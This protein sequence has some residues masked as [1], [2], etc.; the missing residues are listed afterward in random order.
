M[1]ARNSKTAVPTV[2]GEGFDLTEFMTGAKGKT[3]SKAFLGSINGTLLA[4][5]LSRFIPGRKAT[6]ADAEG[7][8]AML[9]RD[10]EAQVAGALK[11]LQTAKA[12][13]ARMTVRTEDG[14]KV[15]VNLSIPFVAATFKG[16]QTR[17][18]NLNVSVEGE[19]GKALAEHAERVKAPKAETPAKAPKARTET[20][21]TPGG[22]GV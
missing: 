12:D 1:A 7:L 10:I 16:E 9:V 21:A 15:T 13:P 17:Y 11:A 6:K 2:T 18:L 22:R 14:A 4:Q 20:P 3:S 19:V 8:K 5:S